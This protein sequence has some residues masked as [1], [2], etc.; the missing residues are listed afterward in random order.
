MWDQEEG[1]GQSWG[2]RV[3]SGWRVSGH[4]EGHRVR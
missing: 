2:Y 3:E 4:G 1:E